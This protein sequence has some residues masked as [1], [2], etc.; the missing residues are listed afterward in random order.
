MLQIICG[1]LLGA[2]DK[3]ARLGS[4]WSSMSCIYCNLVGLIALQTM[5]LRHIAR[6]FETSSLP[7]VNGVAPNFCMKSTGFL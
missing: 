1:D 3:A 6:V 5:V 4:T 2:P 7:F